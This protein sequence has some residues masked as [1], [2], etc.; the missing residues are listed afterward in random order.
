MWRRSLLS[1]YFCFL[2][3]IY[4]DVRMLFITT[5]L[6]C[7]MQVLCTKGGVIIFVIYEYVYIHSGTP[8]VRPPLLQ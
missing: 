4:E 5:N 2:C 3:A 1:L 7:K 6:C 8:L